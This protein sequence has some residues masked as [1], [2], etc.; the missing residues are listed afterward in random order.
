MNN[1]KKSIPSKI[2]TLI[3]GGG[4]VGAGIYRDLALNGVECL[5]IDKKDF[6]SQ[7]S[8]NSSKMF[9]GGIRY[10]ETMNFGLV[11]E[12]LHEKNLWLKLAPHLC[13]EKLFVL[14]I[15]K[16]SKYPLWMMKI[17]VKFYDFLSGFKNSPSGSLTS[18]KTLTKIQ[19]LNSDKLSGSVTYYDAIVDDVKLT[20]D[21]IFDGNQ[22]P[23]AHSYNYVEIQNLQPDGNDYIATLFDNITQKKYELKAKH[24]I[25]ALGPFTDGL[26]KQFSFLNWS[27]LLLTSRGSHIWVKKGKINIDLPMVLQTKDNRIIFAIPHD[28]KILAGTTEDLA[29]GDFFDL[30]ATESEIDY[31]LQTL[32]DY[33]PNAKLSKD[34][35]LYS[36]A[37][38]RPLV[39]TGKSNDPNKT[40]RT[41]HISTPHKNCFVITGGKLTTYR[42][43]GRKITKTICK[44]N[45]INYNASITAKPFSVKSKIG[46]FDNIKD[47]NLELNLINE[48]I[49]NESVRKFE[50]LIVRRLNVPSLKM[51]AYKSS[52]DQLFKDNF[53]HINK[54]LPIT[55]KEIEDYLKN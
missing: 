22:M 16:D 2:D 7:T 3:I 46:P 37:G 15:Y 53:E 11:W 29:T 5:L 52:F 28:D 49:E 10:L 8:Q 39:R 25:F 27:P 12:A 6:G 18:K 17:G 30:K 19:D 51:W 20:L 41:H 32:A 24:V 38:I 13:I 35:I 34:D 55:N 50:D 4:I 48:I 43:M 9:H 23:N 31:L 36:F 42:T 45:D 54:I 14:P 33:F 47:L 44:N 40:S 1:T 26:L 21:T